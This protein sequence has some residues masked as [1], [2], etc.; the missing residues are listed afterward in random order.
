M[1]AYFE[2]RRGTTLRVTDIDLPEMKWLV[3]S[4]FKEIYGSDPVGGVYLLKQQ[5]LKQME[6]YLRRYEL[7]LV[8]SLPVTILRLE[9]HISTVVD[10]F[11]FAGIL[12]RVDVRGDTTWIVDYKT[13]GFGSRLKIDFERLDLEKRST[14]EEAVGSL[15]LPFYC[16]LWDEVD[17]KNPEEIEAMFLLLGKAHLNQ[18][19]EL[20][21][22]KKTD[23]RLYALR[24]ARN[25]I[26]AL[27]GEIVDPEVAFDP[28]LRKKDACFSCDYRHMCGT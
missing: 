15:Q 28:G 18:T 25:L 2:K 17:G 21:L 20:H 27:A 6:A 19:M 5:V 7:P 1:F 14:W 10:G 24:K 23:T 22:F 4:V 8:S 26:T 11:C 13:S 3:E 12:D 16:L 9:H